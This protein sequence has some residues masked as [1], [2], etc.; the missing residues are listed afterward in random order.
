MLGTFQGAVNKT[1]RVHD[2]CAHSLRDTSPHRARRTE[3]S[4]LEHKHAVGGVSREA[5]V[6]SDE[7]HRVASSAALIDPV[8]DVHVR[9]DGCM[10]IDEVKLRVG[11]A[12]H[13]HEI[14]RAT[15][16]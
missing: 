12:I 13:G 8:Y 11:P 7:Y 2:L 14:R 5:L 4:A 16:V 15:V 6:V 10:K 3:H 1:P 9:L